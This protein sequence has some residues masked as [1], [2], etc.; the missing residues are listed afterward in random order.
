M[1]CACRLFLNLM[2]IS[3]VHFDLSYKRLFISMVSYGMMVC[4]W[5]GYKTR[6]MS[7]LL[8]AWLMVYNIAANDFWN[9]DGELHVI[10]YDFFQTLSAVGGLL[11]LIHTG[12]GEL[13]VD[14]L[15][16]KW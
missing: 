8:A 3:M 4:L 13:S 11:L 5:C 10:R 16:K 14:E 2:L 1:L 7:V 6:L 9:R 12:G 15:K